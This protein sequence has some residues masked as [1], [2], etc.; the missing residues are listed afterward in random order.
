MKCAHTEQSVNLAFSC[1]R[2]NVATCN[3]QQTYTDNLSNAPQNK[4][5]PL[6]IIQGVLLSYRVFW[7]NIAWVHIQNIPEAV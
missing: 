4:I 6:V 2:F 3:Y 5:I 1:P 7:N